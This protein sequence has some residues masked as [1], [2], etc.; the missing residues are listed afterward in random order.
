MVQSQNQSKEQ[1]RLLLK[2][3]IMSISVHD[4]KV[5]SAQVTQN[6]KQYLVGKSGKWGAFV[7]LASEPQVNWIEASSQIEWCFVQVEQNGLRF[8]NNNKNYSVQELDGICIPGLGFH[9]NGARLGR[10]GGY[11]D[12]ELQNFNKL[13]IGI[14][15]DL[16]VNDELPYEAHD[17]KVNTIITDQRIVQAA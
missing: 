3:Q 5:M 7:P 12:R 10:G 2:K 17:V 14:A 6:L 8:V 13:K 9:L 1:S 11:Y 16:T 15:F 4:N